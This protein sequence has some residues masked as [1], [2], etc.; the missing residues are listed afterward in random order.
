MKN[1]AIRELGL[2]SCE[3]NSIVEHAGYAF[4]FP[5][6]R[7][8]ARLIDPPEVDQDATVAAKSI[9]R[10]IISAKAG[11]LTFGLREWTVEES[12]DEANR[13][14]D[15]LRNRLVIIVGEI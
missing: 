11:F 1:D 2:I 5:G 4:S 15:R 8:A 14:L 9:L 12:A 7:T 13:R 3:P 10:T 6:L